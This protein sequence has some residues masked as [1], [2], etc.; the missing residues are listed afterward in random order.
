MVDVLEGRTLMGLSMAAYNPTTLRSTPSF[1]C[2]KL[3]NKPT[4]ALIAS[5]SSGAKGRT[6]GG[7]LLQTHD[8]NN[9][10]KRDD[11]N[12]TNSISKKKRKKKRVFFLD[13]NPI[14]YDGST[15]SLHSFAH[16]IS[17]FF[18]QVSLTDPVIAVSSLS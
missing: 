6:P 7:L 5:S 17:L 8:P 9:E 3:V 1:W 13:V 4:A 16:W 14:C 11:D 10:I 15:P 2:T 12:G 18:S